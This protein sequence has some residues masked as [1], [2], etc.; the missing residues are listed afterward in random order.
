MCM[1]IKIHSYFH[2]EWCSLTM[3]NTNITRDYE[4]SQLNLILKTPLQIFKMTLV[5]KKTFLQWVTSQLALRSR[6]RSSPTSG[7][8]K[9]GSAALCNNLR[10]VYYPHW[11]QLR[12]ELWAMG[13]LLGMGSGWRGLGQGVLQYSSS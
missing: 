7:Y 11:S 10:D 9:E 3:S 12:V 2:S 5:K 6:K 4:E 13:W 1:C 8:R